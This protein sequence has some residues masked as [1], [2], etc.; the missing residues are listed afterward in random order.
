METKEDD[1]R[2][3]YCVLRNR[4]NPRA[5]YDPY[6]LQVVSADTARKEKKYWTISASSVTM[7]GNNIWLIYIYIYIYIYSLLMYTNIKN[8][9]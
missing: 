4:D 7:V 3:V 6:N 1:G 9:K 8:T 5:R 2:F